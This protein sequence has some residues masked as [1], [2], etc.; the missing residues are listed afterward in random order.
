M[1]EF[2]NSWR[3]LSAGDGPKIAAAISRLARAGLKPMFSE[4]EFATL[5]RRKVDQLDETSI[6]NPPRSETWFHLALLE[7]QI[8]ANAICY[9]YD[10]DQLADETDY[11]KAVTSIIV[12]AGQ[13][14]PGVAVSAKRQVRDGPYGP[15]DCMEITIQGA[16]EAAFDLI[17]DER[18]D[19]SVI[20]RLNE[21]LPL[22]ATGQFAVLRNGAIVYVRPDRLKKLSS[23]FEP[24]ESYPGIFGSIQGRAPIWALV[25]CLLMGIFSVYSLIIMFSKG[26]P[27]T[28]PGPGDIP[29]SQATAPLEFTIMLT[30]YVL[31]GVG[32]IVAP[33][34]QI[35]LRL[36]GMK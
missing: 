35:A 23:L 28:I 29:I 31:G 22:V 4:R 14:W 8:F 5:A 36:R 20:A 9:Q 26:V 2:T 25:A 17:V 27:Y 10:W 3:S 12:L 11:A 33:L 1:V 34:W 16:S 32:F 13:E 19:L 7:P 21:R 30:I 18:L 15:S 24:S 6:P